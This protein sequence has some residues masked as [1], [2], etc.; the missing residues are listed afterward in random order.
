MNEQFNFDVFLSHSA[1]DKAVVRAVAERLRKDGLRVWPCPPKP[2]GEGGFDEWEVKPEVPLARRMGEGS[3]VRAAKIEEGLGHS[4]LGT[5]NAEFGI[6]QP[7]M[8]ANAFG[9]DSAQLACPAVA[10]VRRRKA[11]TCGRGNL[12]F[13]DP[14]KQG[15]RFLRLD[16]APINSSLPQFL[17]I[18]WLPADREKEYSKLMEGCRPIGAGHEPR[19]VPPDSSPDRQNGIR[20]WIKTAREVELGVPQ[21]RGSWPM[22]GAGRRREENRPILATN[23]FL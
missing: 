20:V 6:A 23:T 17:Y 2:P 9:S 5:R 7:G 1:K 4:K 12:P 14:L 19:T 16:G 22:R 13:R 11:G 3:G 8:S 15:R 18:N 10:S 21:T